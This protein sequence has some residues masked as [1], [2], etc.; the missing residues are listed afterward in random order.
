MS[1]TTAEQLYEQQIKLLPVTERLRLVAIIAHDLAAPTVAE[2]PRPRSLLEL[3]GVGAE[4]WE[5]IDA[6]QYVNALR[7]E[8]DHRP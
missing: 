1:T 5:G 8:W 2:E 7:K 4:I 3:E 6:Q